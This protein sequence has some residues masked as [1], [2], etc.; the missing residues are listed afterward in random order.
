MSLRC[1]RLF[2]LL[3]PLAWRPSLGALESEVPP[4]I[5]GAG[6]LPAGTAAPAS[7]AAAAN[8]AR[9]L[10]PPS[11]TVGRPNPGFDQP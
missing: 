9:Q 7:P 5:A 6:W 4:W 8:L 10:R 11:L 1:I 3:L 2:L